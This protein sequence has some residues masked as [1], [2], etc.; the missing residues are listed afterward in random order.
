[1]L[2]GALAIGT[3][4]T[5]LAGSG[6]FSRVDITSMRRLDDRYVTVQAVAS[7]SRVQRVEFGA[8]GR[9]GTPG[10]HL[11]NGTW[12]AT[13]FARRGVTVGARTW[14]NGKP[15]AYSYVVAK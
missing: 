11:G 2:V 15:D 1:M 12:S 5:A 13:I 8:G 6:L 10:Q 3:A 14:V 9:W 4:A 7:G